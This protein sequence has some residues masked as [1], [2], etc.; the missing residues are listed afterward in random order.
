[1]SVSSVTQCGDLSDL[2]AFPQNSLDWLK[3]LIGFDT[4]SRHSNLNLIEEVARF[5]R[6][7]GL[8]PI[9]TYNT[10]RSKANLFVSVP[11][12]FA[13]LT[14]FADQPIVGGIVL[15]GHTDVVPV[16]GQ[17]WQSDPFVA[18]VQDGR[19]YGR[20]ACDMKGFIACC[21]AILPKAVDR[22]K[23]GKLKRPLHLALSFDEEVGCL[24]APILL[25]DLKKRG[26]TPDYCIVGEPTNMQMVVAHKGIN[27]FRCCVQGKSV[28]SSLTPQG[29]NA[30]SY[31]S[32]LI[33]FID[34]LAKQLQP[35]TDP[36][37]DVPFA[38]LS[39]GTIQ[40]GTATNIVPNFCEFT[41]DFR[42]LPHMPLSRVQTPIQHKID[43]LTQQM[44]QIDPHATIHLE[45]KENVPAMT[46][47]DN[48]TL[49]KF[50]GDLLGSQDHACPNKKNKVAYAT[51][52]GQ[53]SQAGIPTLICGP[54]S[55]EQAHKANEFIELDQIKK[56]TAFLEKLL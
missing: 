18:H 46:D 1:M 5:C 7:L 45:L 23:Q 42:N 10:D 38:T 36:D 3:H 29:V 33:V 40:G 30:I 48:H 50:I 12:H 49:Q 54:G 28:H 37:F 24:G 19:L 22:S 11:T 32:Q 21:L 43:E 17:A 15:S 2:S 34:D 20:G 8:K 55:I 35:E 39:V 51:E 27:V 6:V 9:L 4:V 56:C 44:Q 26:I 31:A 52:G 41:F 53:F 14:N 25:A 16:D 47:Q 13:D